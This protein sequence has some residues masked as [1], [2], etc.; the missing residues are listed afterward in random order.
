MHVAPELQQRDRLLLRTS[1]D[2]IIGGRNGA[3]GGT[4]DFNN[5]ETVET[6][7]GYSILYYTPTNYRFTHPF[8]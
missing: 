7:V 6:Q 2:G 1:Q 3:T 5:T 4:E 8:N